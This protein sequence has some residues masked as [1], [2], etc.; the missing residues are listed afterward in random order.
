MLFRIRMAPIA[1]VRP[2]IHLQVGASLGPKS[3]KLK[4]TS[5]APV[6]V[7]KSVVTS[8]TE[9][10][11]ICPSLEG[12]RGD[13]IWMGAGRQ[14]WGAGAWLTGRQRAAIAARGMDT[15]SMGTLL[16]LSMNRSGLPRR[17]LLVHGNHFRDLGDLRNVRKD[18]QQTQ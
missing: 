4:P 3:A 18:R 7:R 9:S 10:G 11:L 12:G 15:Y 6:A 14:A 1:P 2:P 16:M 8:T 5:I 17:G 13:E